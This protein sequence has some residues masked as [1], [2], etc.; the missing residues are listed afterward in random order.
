MRL[1]ARVSF[2]RLDEMEER[3]S[4]V[5]FPIELALPFRVVEF[6]PIAGR[7]AEVQEC[8]LR[9]GVKVLSIHAT[10]GDLSR[11]DCREWA[12]PAMRL[13]DDLG[14]ASVTFHPSRGKNRI[15]LQHSMIGSL[16]ALQREFRAIA[17]VETFT[18]KQRLLLPEEIVALSL[19]MVLDT[20]YIHDDARVFDLL[21]RHHEKIIAVHLSS[22]GQGK[23]HQPI[24]DFCLCVAKWLMAVN[25]SGFIILEYMPEYHDRLKPDLDRPTRWYSGRM[26]DRVAQ[27][28]GRTETTGD[29]QG[30][31]KANLFFP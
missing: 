29:R 12:R 11:E 2:D 5:D 31:C 9:F 10:Q 26:R 16:K 19:P 1:G 30:N 3:L 18:D 22:R 13:A 27:H 28:S 20:S 6:L 15:N 21:E 14:A 25:W 4:G 8:V 7:M 17:A 24:D 23:Q